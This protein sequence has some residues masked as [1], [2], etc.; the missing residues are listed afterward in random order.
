M[1][2]YRGLLWVIKADTGR[3]DHGLNAAAAE[4]SPSDLLALEK[5]RRGDTKKLMIMVYW[6]LRKRISRF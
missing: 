5:V 3:L 4:S 2:L 6:T 1:G